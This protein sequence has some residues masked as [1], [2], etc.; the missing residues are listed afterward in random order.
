MNNSWLEDPVITEWFDIIKNQRTA[1]NYR[2]E[3]PYYLEFVQANTEYKTP[4]Q[5]IESRIQQLR[6]QARALMHQNIVEACSMGQLQRM[7][8]NHGN[9]NYLQSPILSGTCNQKSI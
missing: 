7:Y 9:Q 4:S 6:S 5:I 2:R 1:A 3:F 8:C